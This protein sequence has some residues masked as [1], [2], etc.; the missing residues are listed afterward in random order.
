MKDGWV[1]T[2]IV[3]DSGIL[4]DFKTNAYHYGEFEDG[5]IYVSRIKINELRVIC[6]SVTRRQA[7]ELM[8]RLQGS[9]LRVLDKFTF[10][11]CCTFFLDL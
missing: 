11:T 8:I 6:Y 2:F 10:D 7:E 1:Y 3:K 4:D 9:K 5:Y